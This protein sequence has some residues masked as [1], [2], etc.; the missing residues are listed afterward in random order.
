MPKATSP[1]DFLKKAREK[2]SVNNKHIVTGEEIKKQL[3]PCTLKRYKRMMAV[4]E[5][6]VPTIRN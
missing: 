2:G 5:Q 1:K 3:E 4:W 6:Y